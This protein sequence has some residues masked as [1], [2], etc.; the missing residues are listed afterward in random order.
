MVA[1]CDILLRQLYT[2]HFK[3]SFPK[4]DGNLI[5]HPSKGVMANLPHKVHLSLHQ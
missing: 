2:L 1:L 3:V 4:N 5:T